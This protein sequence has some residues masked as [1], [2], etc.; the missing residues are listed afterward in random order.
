MNCK[1]VFCQLAID[2]AK[3]SDK[4]H[5]GL[6]SDW[7]VSITTYYYRLLLTRLDLQGDNIVV[8]VIFIKRGGSIIIIII[9]NT[10]IV[11]MRKFLPII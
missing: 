7:A 2:E 4:F 11:I 8:P 6:D 10:W 3:D 5:S 1:G 9:I